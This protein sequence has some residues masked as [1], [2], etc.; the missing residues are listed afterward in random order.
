MIGPQKGVTKHFSQ[1]GQWSIKNGLNLCFWTPH[2]FSVFQARYLV[3]WK[4]GPRDCV[5]TYVTAVARGIWAGC[6]NK[7]NNTFGSHFHI[8]WY[9]CL[10]WIKPCYK[11]KSQSHSL[12]RRCREALHLQHGH[13]KWHSSHKS[14]RERFRLDVRTVHQRSRLPEEFVQSLYLEVCKTQLEDVLSNPVWPQSCPWFEHE[15]GLKSPR[16]SWIPTWII[17]QYYNELSIFE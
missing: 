10:Y 16:G 14:K 7:A 3:T 2:Q 12:F 8:S 9:W 13:T 15:V 4:H 17:L 1:Q 11:L 6:N 5:Q